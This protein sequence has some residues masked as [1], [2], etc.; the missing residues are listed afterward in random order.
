MQRGPERRGAQTETLVC[1]PAGAKRRG[2][3]A[4]KPTLLAAFFS[5]VSTLGT[6][7]D[8]LVE[9]GRCERDDDQE[10]YKQLLRTTM[11]GHGPISSRIAFYEPAERLPDTVL[12]VITKMLRRDSLSNG[13]GGSGG[14]LSRL[15]RNMLAMG[16]E[17]RRD[18]GMNCVGGD[19]SVANHF[20]NSSVVELGKRW[21][22]QL[23]NRTGTEA[24]AHLLLCT[25]IFLPLPN[26]GY[27]QISGIPLANTPMPQH[28]KIQ[29]ATARPFR[30]PGV[31]GAKRKRGGTDLEDSSVG[32]EDSGVG[33]DL[34]D[35]G[36]AGN[37]RARKVR[38]MSMH[39]ARSSVD[40]GGQP[41]CAGE[42]PLALASIPI[43]RGRMLFAAP[44]LRPTLDWSLPPSFPLNQHAS[45]Q[46]L[47]QHIFAKVR[48]YAAAPPAGVLALADRMLRLHRKFNYRHHLFRLCPAPWQQRQQMEQ[49]RSGD[50][51]APGPLDQACSTTDVFAFLQHCVRSVVP[52][53]L[54][55][56][57][58][59]HR[60]LYAA[61]RQLVTASRFEEPSLHEVVQRFR[62]GEA[63]T[64][65]DLQ[66]PRAM[67]IYASMV[68]WV[69][70]EFAARIVRKYFYVTEGSPSR[71][72]LYYFRND[73]WRTLARDAWRELEKSGMYVQRTSAEA[74][75]VDARRTLGH[76]RMR[77]LPKEQGFRAIV[78]MKRS[79][80]VRR[81]PAGPAGSAPRGFVERPVVS[82]NKRMADILAALR[83]WQRR[84]PE[85]F[86]T[87][88]CGPD[89]VHARLMAFKR[90]IG[91]TAGLGDTAG[92]GDTTGL[93][94]TAGLGD[95]RLYIAKLD[96]ARAYD[97]IPQAQLLAQ[98]R[99]C[100]PDEEMA[101]QKYWSL[102][103]SLNRPRPTYA[104]HGQPAGGLVEFRGLARELAARR[105]DLIVG[106][107]SATTYIHTDAMFA[108]IS[109]H[110]QQSTVRLQSRLLRPV[111]G[112]PQGSML[113]ALLCNFFYGQLE[114]E[115]LAPIIDTRSTLV[116]RLI[117]DI[118]VVS[119]EQAQV[120]AIVDRMRQAFR[121]RGCELNAAKTLANFALTVGGLRARQTDGPGFPW[122]GMLIDER[123]LNAMVDYSRLAPPA[124]LGSFLA[125]ALRREAGQVLRQ[126]LLTAVQLKII[127]LYVGGGLNSRG[128]VLLNL[129]QNF[130]LCAKKFHVICLRLGIC[131]SNQPFLASV[132]EDMLAMAY[133]ALKSR[134]RVRSIA[135][136]VV[137]WLGAHAF[138]AVLQRKQ[139]RYAWLLA[140]LKAARRVPPAAEADAWVVGSPR[141]CAVHDVSY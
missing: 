17:L 6:Y 28:K 37:P 44:P 132:V 8:A 134:C 75:A 101:V 126:K 140:R 21:W 61:L 141:N 85:L 87:A 138:H 91:D 116:M 66:H 13:G 102:L 15:G 7:M 79:Y 43:A 105:K 83:P 4:G 19:S 54:V 34:D 22:T 120:V 73:V 52:R 57:K 46:A 121:A 16:Y 29:E 98:L 14:L 39:A 78:N 97:T 31:A 47:V 72:Q 23:L 65:L 63:A 38:K 81:G 124:R 67:D 130:V 92:I 3:K 103:P 49:P 107:Q 119:R 20:V 5:N 58:R 90:T 59:N 94:G 117:D 112:I 74:A 64:W 110:L 33:P 11:V 135:P 104:R 131:A 86:G 69:L 125:I 71:Y 2:A 56:G 12:K 51:E 60:R 1:P 27:C 10:A 106:D 100:L 118:L 48:H 50:A 113:S 41:S 76:S 108:L 80:V 36:E 127:P 111:R 115:H 25:S 53:D 129:Y 89:D 122:C 77:L 128:T 114:R 45:G 136:D 139:T 18:G 84:C 62:L 137:R 40:G 32:P 133:I 68:R 93:G 123:S 55:G 24:M 95:A 88:I 35:D 30:L 70:S 96:I 26:G 82:T 42:P 99:A 109:E 9:G